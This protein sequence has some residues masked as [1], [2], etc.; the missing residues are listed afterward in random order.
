MEVVRMS[1]LPERLTASRHCA[2]TLSELLNL[3]TSIK[4]RYSF[5]DRYAGSRVVSDE[6]VE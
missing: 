4:R 3:F 6:I 2:L 5:C 1:Q